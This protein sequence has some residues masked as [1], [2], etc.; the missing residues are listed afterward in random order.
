MCVFLFTTPRSVRPTMNGYRKALLDFVEDPSA[1]EPPVLDPSKRA[2]LRIQYSLSAA[3]ESAWKFEAKRMTPSERICR[4]DETSLVYRRGRESHFDAVLELSD[5]RITNA[6]MGRSR[7]H[8]IEIVLT[9]D[10]INRKSGRSFGR[11][12]AALLHLVQAISKDSNM[13]FKY[14]TNEGDRNRLGEMLLFDYDLS[15]FHFLPHG[16]SGSEDTFSAAS[17]HAANADSSCFGAEAERLVPRLVEG[18]H[19]DTRR[20]YPNAVSTASAQC[21]AD[22][23]A[24]QEVRDSRSLLSTNSKYGLLTDHR[25]FASFLSTS[26][27]YVH[28]CVRAAF[29][30][31]PFCVGIKRNVTSE[32]GR[33][34][35]FFLCALPF[36]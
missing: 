20:P 7:R 34:S 31:Y 4:Q 9:L 10:G 17:V 32:L 29:E 15:E 1:G 3:D 14:L 19:F 35:V 5:E 25:A 8:F 36:L 13:L 22:V 26:G 33:T 6:I 21:S 16:C 27:A 30:E 28:P 11:M 12:E 23:G 24:Q 18:L 2:V